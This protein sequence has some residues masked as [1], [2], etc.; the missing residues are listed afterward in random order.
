MLVCTQPRKIAAVSLATHVSKEMGSNVGQLVG[1][2]VGMQE[3]KTAVTKIMFMTDHILL[4]ECLKDRSLSKYS[5]IIIDEAHERSIYTDLLLGLVKQCL[6]SR[7]DLRV[8][9]TSATID[10]KIFVEYF[11]GM[12]KCPVLKVSG[13]TFPVDVVWDFDQLN[14]APFPQ[15]YENKAVDK[16]IEIHRTTDV[17]EGDILV[18]LTSAVET[19]KCVDKFKKAVGVTDNVCLQLHGRLRTDEQQLVFEKSPKGKRKVVFATNSA[20]TS[21]TIDGVKFVID[22]GVV[23]EMKFDPKK[24]MSSLD[25]VPVSQSSADQRKGRAGRTSPG[26]CYRLYSEKDYN[27]MSK[28][29]LPEIL[30]IQVSQAILK[31]LELGVDPLSFDYVEAPSKSTMQSAMDELTSMGAVDGNGC[32]TDTGRWVARLPLEPKFGMMIKQGIDLDIPSEAIVVASCC[33]QSGIFYRAG[34]LEDKKVA[35]MK[36]LKF[37]HE[38]GDLLTM[39]SVYREWEKEP[40]KKKGQWCLANSVNGK[41]IKGVRDMMNEILTILRKEA[42]LKLKHV[43]ADAAVSDKKVKKLVFDCMKGNLA[44]YLG[45]EN[46]GFLVVNRHQRVTIHPSSTLMSL[47]LQPTWVVYNRLLRTSADYMTEVTPVEE[48]YLEEAKA[49]KKITIDEAFLVKQRVKQTEC[50]PVGR[51]VFWKFVGPFHKNRREVEMDISDVCNNTTVVVE[52]KKQRGEIVLFCVPEYGEIAADMLRE[53]VKTLPLQLKNERLEQA[54]LNKK[55]ESTGT[56]LLLKEGGIVESVLL[57]SQFRS[58]NIK[59]KAFTQYALSRQ[60]IEDRLSCYG[61]IEDLWQTTGKKNQNSIFWGRVTFANERFAIDAYDDVKDDPDLNFSLVPIT[62]QRNES[63][64]QQGY[65]L[66]VTWCRRPAKDHCFVYLER[67]EDKINLIMSRLNVQGQSLRISL[68]RQQS[69]LY[70]KG[71]KP[72]ATEDDIYGGLEECLGLDPGEGNG[73][74]KVVIPRVNVILRAD[75]KY[76]SERLLTQVLARYAEPN[77]FK[78]SVIPYRQQTVTVIAYVTFT[79][80]DVAEKVCRDICENK[81]VVERYPI[82]ADMEFKSGIHVHKRVYNVL[83][84]DIKR[85]RS[86]YQN[87][88]ATVIDVRELKS[89]HYTVDIKSTNLQNLAR[90]KVRFDDLLQGQVLAASEVENLGH[91]FSKEGRNKLE[92]IERNTKTLITPDERQ[93]KITVQGQ[94]GGVQNAVVS[95][96]QEIDKFV[97]T[98]EQEIRLKGDENPPGL[99][100]ALFLRYGVKFAGLRSECG[101]SKISINMRSR[102]ICLAGKEEAL[103]KALELVKE[104]R[105]KLNKGKADTGDTFLPDCPVCLCPIEETEIFRLEFCGHAY[106]KPCLILQLQTAIRDREFPVRCSA[107]NCEEPLVIRDFKMQIKNGTIK[108]SQLAMAAL[109]AY[110]SEHSE[111]YRFCITPDCSMVYKVTSTGNRFICGICSKHICT[112]CHLEYHNGLTCAMYKSAKQDGDSVLK[113]IQEDPDNRKKCPKCAFG[114]EKIDGCDHMNCKCGAHICWKCL[115]YFDSIRSCYGHLSRAHGTF[116]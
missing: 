26:I 30:R 78:V 3:K 74:F 38:G 21:I 107:E 43:F 86:H 58:L 97:N 32:I 72:S 99:L 5:C 48:S 69:D 36:K 10:P 88:K 96:K 29:G 89:G 25:V 14:D 84:Q 113:W 6:E 55:G 66:K 52:A 67:P 4:N 114:I 35:D 115:E 112:S 80:I 82:S 101:L 50:I 28:T 85:M 7:K 47:G 49:Q 65:T 95:I 12:D 46:A 76:E 9:I 64:T 60:E 93:M 63:T 54:I 23:K 15:N 45:H 90:A 100:K 105:D 42:D 34:S 79:D 73:R 103:A 40:E 91:L 98:K 56:R 57:P 2:R 71:L 51:H 24:N 94:Q 62:Y 77:S 39:L 18:F 44:Y 37:C 1:Y 41:S 70:I 16:A 68:S 92:I 17:D 75:E 108:Q 116:V 104:E 11:G 111:E 19:E 31:L 13:R 102:E 59:E 87:S 8:V 27:R 33:S 61:P 20:E 110:V 53:A 22:T 81:P 106:C 83:S 109:N